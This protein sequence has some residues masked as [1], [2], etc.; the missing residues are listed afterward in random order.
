MSEKKD[1][2]QQSEDYTNDDYKNSR[3]HSTFGEKGDRKLAEELEK[4]MDKG[5]IKK[6]K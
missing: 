4:I 2:E 1:K 6:T 3:W 5:R